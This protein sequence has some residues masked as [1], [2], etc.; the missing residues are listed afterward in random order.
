MGS[1]FE[2]YTQPIE[3][4]VKKTEDISGLLVGHKGQDVTDRKQE[5]AARRDPNGKFYVKVNK[6][7][8]LFNPYD[9]DRIKSDKRLVTG[10]DP[11]YF[12]VECDEECFK[13]YRLFL[14]RNVNAYFNM[15]QKSISDG[16]FKTRHTYVMTPEHSTLVDN[17]TDIPIFEEITD[18]IPEAPSQKKKTAKKRGKKSL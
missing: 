2:N 8:K 10:N 3:D 14:Q 16:S 17:P 15:A 1:R 6:K 4:N 12:M 7:N 9:E 5:F 18:M 11:V 13:Y